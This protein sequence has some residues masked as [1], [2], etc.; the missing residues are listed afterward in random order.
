MRAGIEPQTSSR[1]QNSKGEWPMQAPQKHPD[2]PFTQKQVETFFSHLI[3]MPNGCINW[4]GAQC[5]EYGRVGI[6]G[7]C[8][9]SHRAAYVIAHGAI[10]DGK[11]IRHKCDTP[12]C[13]NELH[14]EPGTNKQNSEDMVVRGRCNTPRGER[15]GASRLT[16][17][18]VSAIKRAINE[19]TN[20][21]MELSRIHNVARGTIHAIRCELSWS[22]VEPRINDLIPQP[23]RKFSDIDH[24]VIRDLWRDGLKLKALA[25]RYQCRV[26]T[27][28]AIISGK[29]GKLAPVG[30]RVLRKNQT[31]LSSEVRQE[32]LRRYLAGEKQIDLAKE[33]GMSKN[34]ISLALQSERR[35]AQ[36]GGA[37]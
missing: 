32:L 16:F 1:S 31:K 12:L 37:V 6:S 21:Q 8:W 27:I 35:I 2:C 14:L 20:T 7:K 22:E 4:L 23:H 17:E 5:G 33:C 13:C 26:D 34:G 36:A 15:H 11:I 30:L 19:G 9:P 18:T 28:Q 25:E 29:R 10:P 3:P 24:A